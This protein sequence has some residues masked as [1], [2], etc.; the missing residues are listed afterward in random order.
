MPLASAQVQYSLLS[1]GPDQEATLELCRDL[2]IAVIAYSPL[3]LGVLSPLIRSLTAELGPQ[4]E[5]H[6]GAVPGSG[7]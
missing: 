5:G 1:K 6:P 2:G 3:G 4:A 7:H